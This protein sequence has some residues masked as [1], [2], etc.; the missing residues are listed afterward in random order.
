MA[1][2]LIPNLLSISSTLSTWKI[3]VPK[4]LNLNTSSCSQGL[5][6]GL[7]D[8]AQVVLLSCQFEIGL[9]LCCVRFSSAISPSDSWSCVECGV[10]HLFG[11]FRTSPVSSLHVEVGELLIQLCLQYI[12]KLRSNPCNPAFSSVVG[13]GFR[14]CLRLD[15][16]P[17]ASEWIS[18]YLTWKSTSIV[19][20]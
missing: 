16:I 3:D 9:W 7:C 11:A 13:T 15:K 19:L 12:S 8:F 17:S 1:E 14:R 10:A 6:N 20:H 4:P 5:G 18:T 2:N